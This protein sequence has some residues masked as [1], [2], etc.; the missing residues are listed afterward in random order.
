LAELAQT[1]EISDLK[2]RLFSM[3]SHEFRTPLSTILVSTQML[4]SSEQTWSEE[5]KV[6]NLSRIQSAAKTMAQLLSDILTLGRAEAGKLEFRPEPVNLVS[7]CQHLIEEL[8]DSME[9]GS[10]INFTVQGS[11]T[12][13]YIDSK[14]LQSILSNLL[15]N[16]IKYSSSNS[17]IQF[18][19]NCTSEAVTFLVKDHGIGIAPDDQQRLYEAFHRGK[20]VGDVEGTGLGLAVVKTCVDLHGGQINVESKMNSGTTFTVTLPQ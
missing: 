3:V 17:S 8:Q 6:K 20:N 4:T 18:T 5:K 13:A 14:L 12:D 7:F 2:M 15:S 9:C 16:A 19:L 1:K 11:F 10:R